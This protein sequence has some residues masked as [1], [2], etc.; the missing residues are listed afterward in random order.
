[1]S[2]SACCDFDL[3]VEGNVTRRPSMEVDLRRGKGSHER[4][5]GAELCLF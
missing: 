3:E 5:D 4:R 2:V 1:M